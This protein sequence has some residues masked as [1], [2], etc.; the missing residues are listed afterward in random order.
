MQPQTTPAPLIILISENRNWSH[1]WTDP[2]RIVSTLRCS[3]LRLNRATDYDDSLVRR[4]R[5]NE[6]LMSTVMIDLNE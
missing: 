2:S 6:D 3:Q 4:G 5:V 1:C